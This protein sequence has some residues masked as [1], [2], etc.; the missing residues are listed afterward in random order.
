MPSFQ[1]LSDVFEAALATVGV[2]M[3]HLEPSVDESCDKLYSF[4][5]AYVPMCPFQE[6]VQPNLFSITIYSM[7][8]FIAGFLFSLML[9]DREKKN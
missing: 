2:P 9:R 6:L 4:H 3:L 7:K 5:V 8:L 1:Q